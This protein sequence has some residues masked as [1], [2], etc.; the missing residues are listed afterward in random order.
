[1]MDR[2]ILLDPHCW[3]NGREIHGIHLDGIQRVQWIW[4]ARR[5][6]TPLP[7][8][9]AHYNALRAWSFFASLLSSTTLYITL[10]YKHY[11]V[12]R[13]WSFFVIHYITMR[14]VRG[15]ALL[16]ITLDYIKMRC[17]R[18]ASLFSITLN[19]ITMRCMRGASLLS[20]ITFLHYITLHYIHYITICC[21]HGAS[22]LSSTTLFIIGFIHFR[23]GDQ[24]TLKCKADSI[25]I[26]QLCIWILYFVFHILYFYP[27]TL[28]CIVSWWHFLFGWKKRSVLLVCDHWQMWVNISKFSVVFNS[29]YFI[30]FIFVSKP[31][32]HAFM[33]LK[34]Y[35]YIHT[36]RDR[37]GP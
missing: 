26:G 11:N 2:S 28:P 37:G 15:A 29:S 16:S 33:F 17:V 12:L 21:Q 22:L 35:N 24:R 34:L 14:Y 19:Y 8:L 25:C 20:S 1:M 23:C 4:G 7:S 5:E 10:H 9:N 30:N 13:A 3:I 6:F 31:S 32:F 36:T 18:G 27:I